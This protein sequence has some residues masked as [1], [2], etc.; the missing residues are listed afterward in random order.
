MRHTLEG[1][2]EPTGRIN[3][4]HG[5]LPVYP[6]KVRINIV[7]ENGSLKLHKIIEEQDKIREKLSKKLSGKTTT[8][9]IR[10]WRDKRCM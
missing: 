1:V 2:L 7:E 4:N 9:I 10:E 5:K 3:L 8:E 6:V